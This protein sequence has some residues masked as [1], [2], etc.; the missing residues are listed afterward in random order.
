MYLHFYILYSSLGNRKS[1]D[2][3]LPPAPLVS[4]IPDT[5]AL[6]EEIENRKLLGKLSHICCEVKPM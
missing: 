3:F 5:Q 4:E 2:W 1:L 6:E